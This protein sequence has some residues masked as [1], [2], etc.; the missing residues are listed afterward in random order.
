MKEKTE[1]LEDQVQRLAKF[2]MDNCEGYPNESEGAIDCAIRIIGDTKTQKETINDK[3]DELESRITSG[4]RH[5]S[6]IF[7]AEY[8]YRKANPESNMDVPSIVYEEV[9]RAYDKWTL[10]KEKLNTSHPIK[11]H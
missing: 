2:I 7:A 8:A 1:S 5:E 11:E 3:I 9:E 4:S 6:I 10:K